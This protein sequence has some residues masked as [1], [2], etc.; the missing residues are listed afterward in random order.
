MVYH[1]IRDSAVTTDSPDVT[2]IAVKRASRG[3]G[4]ILR[5]YA[6]FP[7][8]SDIAVDVSSLGPGTGRAFL[9]DVRERDIEP[10][11]VLDGKV[12]LNMMGSVAT[13]RLLPG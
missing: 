12:H 9:C 3:E 13:L 7:L 1:S 6:P 10:L 5:L 11:E 8:E 2:V 4:V